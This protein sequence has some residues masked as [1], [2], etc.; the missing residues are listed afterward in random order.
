M[1]KYV[2]I[3]V[4]LLAVCAGHPAAAQINIAVVDVDTLLNESTAGKSIQQQL[5]AKRESFQKEFSTK[6]KSFRDEEKAIVAKKDKISAEAFAAERTKFEA[7]LV[8]TQKL[9]KSRRTSLDKGLTDAMQ[10]LRKGIMDVTSKIAEEKKYQ[11][12]LNRD[13]VVIVQKE[14]DITADVLAALN[15]K[16]ATIVLKVQ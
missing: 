9:I 10:E 1:K 14:M 6:E 16:I 4:C 3:L 2:L 12:V 15:A 7:K 13:A 8:D 5:K 11:I